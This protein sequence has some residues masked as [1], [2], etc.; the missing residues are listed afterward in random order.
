MGSITDVPGL[1]VGQ[2]QNYEAL[3]GCTVMLFPQ[4]AVA[5][6]EVR[7]SAPGTRETDVLEPANLV[8]RVNALALCGGSAFGLAAVTG[9][10]E[11]LRQNGQGHKTTRGVVPIVPAAVIYDL[12]IGLP[13]VFP[14]Q[15]MGYL[16]CEKA[17]R[18]VQEGSAGVGT[19]ATV[20]KLMGLEHAMKSGVG[21]SSAVVRLRN[22]ETGK[23]NEYMVGAL[24]V[25]NA[26]GDIYKGDRILAGICNHKT[27]KLLDTLLLMR[28]QDFNKPEL[29]ASSN[30]TLAVV[31]TDY[32]LNK[33]AARKLAQISHNALGRSIRP[34]HT[35]FDGDTVFAVSTAEE[36]PGHFDPMA[37]T[38]LGAQA[39]EVLVE[40]IENSVLHTE[41]AA[42]L[43]SARRKD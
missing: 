2:A 5:G 20:G 19:G 30:T 39:T 21:T 27:G 42:G 10:M 17:G 4:G 18:E 32:P 38:C 25:T 26:L 28:E 29:L 23:V 11:F 3:T 1:L 43:P 31:A 34:V 35:M 9:V 37:F 15:Q 16:A 8:H 13:D 22:G 40:A 7:G 33:V 6:V 12:G 41:P 14:D 24:V 36:M